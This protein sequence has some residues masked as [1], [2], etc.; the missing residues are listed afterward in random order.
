MLAQ[1]T[2]DLLLA[3]IEVVAQHQALP[4]PGRESAQSAEHGLP[5]GQ[6]LLRIGGGRSAHS[7]P[8][9]TL[10][11]LPAPHGGAAL[12]DH[13]GR[14]VLG[15]ARSATRADTSVHLLDL[16]RRSQHLRCL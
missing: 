11:G 14:E 7:A 15:I 9:V 12:V 5:V 4:L 13:H 16:G 10:H 6:G 2:G 8:G 3:P 1:G